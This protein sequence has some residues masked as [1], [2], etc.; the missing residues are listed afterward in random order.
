MSEPPRISHLAGIKPSSAS[1][2]SFWLM[3]VVL[4][5]L[6]AA[7][8]GIAFYF[9]DPH[10]ERLSRNPWTYVV[11]TPVVLG[12]LSMLLSSI[13]SRV[14]EKSMQ[15]AF[16]LSVLIHLGLL[17][18]AVNIVIFSRMWPDVLE[19]L[20]AQREQLRQDNLH[21]KQYHIVA[22]HTQSGSRPDYLE[23]VPTHHQP[24]EADSVRSP[25]LALS[26][27]PQD[28]LFSPSPKVELTA[29][30]H[31]T[32]RQ[33]PASSVP[34]MSER[35]A[36]LSRNQLEAQQP[37]APR[38]VREL[39][40]PLLDP[41]AKQP[42]ELQ[43]SRD[44]LERSAS[45]RPADLAEPGVPL[46]RS[47]A[48]AAPLARVE[49][50]ES[51]S[52]TS[53]NSAA[54]RLAR[55]ATSYER[56][57]T[58]TELSAPTVAP[59][60]PAQSSPRADTASTQRRSTTATIPS[61]SSTSE[62]SSPPTARLPPS[63]LARNDDVTA[64]LL[65]ERPRLAER[66]AGGR[67]GPAAPQSMPIY[68]VPEAGGGAAQQPRELQATAVPLP[69][70]SRG[71]RRSS[72]ASDLPDLPRSQT[73][74]GEMSTGST[75]AGRSPWQLATES[76]DGEAAA[77]DIAQL[78]GSVGAVARGA[79][80]SAAQPSNSPA[81]VRAAL[82]AE[83][84]ESATS[85]SSAAPELVARET[86]LGSSRRRS[87]A[88]APDSPLRADEAAPVIGRSNLQGPEPMRA[89]PQQP[90]DDP[91][92]IAI[93][94]LARADGARAVPAAGEVA[95]P[96]NEA[97]QA[98]PT[99]QLAGNA[100]AVEPMNATAGVRQRE[101]ESVFSTPLEIDGPLGAGGVAE[102]LRQ[103]GPLLARRDAKPR[104]EAPQ[105]LTSQRFSRQEVGGP[106]AA[107]QRIPIPRPAFQQRI[108]RVRDREGRD[109]TIAEPQTELAIERGLA[110]LAK[111]Q[112]PD[113]SWRLQDFDTA[114]L[115][116][117]DTAAT[118]LAVLSFQ[119]AGYTHKQFKYSSVVDEAIQFLVA[120]Q[121]DD[122]DLYIRQDPAS[123]QNA[124][125]YSHAIAAL[126][127]CEAYGMT[128]DQQLRPHAQRA[129]DFMVE[130]QDPRLGGWRYRPSLGTDT[131]VT[132]W[133][134]LA[135]KSGQLAGLDVP[136][137][138]FA[139]IERYLQASQNSAAEPHLYRYNPFAADT[140]QQRHG[141]EP[142]AVMTSVGL[143]MRLYCGWGR[144]RSEMQAGADHLLNHLPDHG[145]PTQSMRDTYYWYYATQVLYH[146]RDERWQRWHDRLYPLLIEHQITTGELAGS[147]DPMS[148]TPDLWA[149]Y[150]GRLYVTTMNLLSLEVSYRHLP[151]YEAPTR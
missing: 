115:M 46:E 88:S 114:V 133:F 118:G 70:R 74:N 52:E 68:G 35:A 111:H 25:T 5:S 92:L 98:D 94:P 21:A 15:V 67:T 135:L 122:G 8:V 11:A 50:S 126:A 106:L 41:A 73:W 100:E 75:L 148:P 101:R 82:P 44:S 105:E 13:V 136:E 64:A 128:Q 97:P 28:N 127:L 43:A 29:N 38:D 14:V 120:H 49:L 89:T 71:A 142:T 24:T 69:N 10:D 90:G 79:S 1:T 61:L 22:S 129:V 130:S 30:P 125:L 80:S 39:P 144:D 140:P 57:R 45:G 119:G 93:A 131:S 134:L 113:G 36:S 60:S 123:D 18:Y 51:P 84:A 141:L 107:G 26:R 116:R 19:S 48:N 37:A 117:S 40:T 99:G 20:E 27:S 138:T 103:P 59:D 95:V 87:T 139:S 32:E 102:A 72:L 16:L 78:D 9:L 151:L 110:F 3:N 65:E 56:P 42:P 86:G 81:E 121:Q 104:S 17:V 34:S 149:R 96:E 83:A 63:P 12:L 31:L 108:D 7:I 109:E 146:M 137:E 62:T 55:G 91:A 150:G 124:W 33:Q 145:S 47:E 112:R 53:P 66:I 2:D 76:A 23:P 58:M 147:W 77:V 85:P 4:L 132:G 54:V 6:G 143:L